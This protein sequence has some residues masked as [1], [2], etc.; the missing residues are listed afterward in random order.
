MRTVWIKT[1]GLTAVD[2]ESVHTALQLGGSHD[3]HYRPWE[4]GENQDEAHVLIMDADSFDAGLEL[5]SLPNNIPPH[6]IRVG[7]CA[8]QEG[9]YQLTRPLVGTD[10]LAL[11]D[12]W[13]DNVPLSRPS[14]LNATIRMNNRPVVRQVL[15]ASLPLEEAMYLRARMALAYM[16][17]LEDLN[18]VPE[19]LEHKKVPQHVWQYAFVYVHGE[20]PDAWKWLQSLRS[21]EFKPEKIIAVLAPKYSHLA[22]ECIHRGCSSVLQA[23][24]QPASVIA[25]LQSL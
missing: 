12:S 13:F 11:L 8:A 7:S 16:T 20:Q 9:V 17:D 14:P 19:W 21:M 15:L 25:C 24:L 22:Q 18:V 10:L 6:I 2:V 23:P 3:V 4:P 1:V 5:L